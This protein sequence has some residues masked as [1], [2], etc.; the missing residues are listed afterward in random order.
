M[1]LL[2]MSLSGAIFI[3]IVIVIR[4]FT[5]HKLPKITFL[6]LWDIALL[7]LLLP[8]TF[9]FPFSVYSILRR[10]VPVLDTLESGIANFTADILPNQPPGMETETVQAV[11]TVQNDTISVSVF[12]IIWAVGAA[13]TAAFFIVQIFRCQHEFKTALPVQ[14]DI[15]LLWRREHPLWRT[16]DIR[17]LTGLST[18][19]TYGVLHPVIL[20]PKHTDWSNERQ[21]QYIL[22]HEYVHIRRFDMIR[23]LIASA[24][25][26]IHWFNPLVWIMYIMFQRD[27]E[28]SCD[29]CVI[30]HFGRKHRKEYAM[31]LL[32][33]EEQRSTL[34]PFS[35]YFSK[36]ATEERIKA[37][38]KFKKK[39]I[40]AL[41]FAVI[42]VGIGAVV[43][44]AK[45]PIANVTD[46]GD[47]LRG[48]AP[49]FYVS[50]G[51]AASKHI[52][53][54]PALFDPY[55]TDMKIW[56]FAVE[57]LDGDGNPEVILSVFGAAGDMGGYLILH[58]MDGK[59][60]G[61]PAN[62]RTL[63]NLKEDG[64]YSYSDPTGVVEGGICS[65][66][67]FTETGYTIDKI[68][69]GQGTYKGWESFVVNHQTATEEEFLTSDAEQA[70]KPDAAWYDFTTE[71]VNS[72]F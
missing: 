2:Q 6:A 39:T 33:M 38:M 44:F 27:I 52:V 40:F 45:A 34:T 10:N 35:N 32:H 30:R 53:D 29:E 67:D 17:Q 19:L 42:I 11:L 7:R 50:E 60:Y 24:A 55:D 61:Y 68:T 54:V 51:T 56:N 72:G 3:F 43:I 37:I 15:I 69:Y 1:N 47:I 8:V 5:I 64:T 28:L 49:F 63:M 65:I 16:I 57:D 20:I 25:L 46:F 36:N 70:K 23:K 12:F 26:C 48:E 41:T 31:T 14:N 9:R 62:N 59:I 13:I 71:N 66:A 18:P 22:F 4:A 58:Q 21:M